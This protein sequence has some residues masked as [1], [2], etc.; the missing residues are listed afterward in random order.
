MRWNSCA[1]FCGILLLHQF[2]ALPSWPWLL[3][4]LAAGIILGKY[5]HRTALWFALGC[6]W[7][8]HDGAGYLARL[9]PQALEREELL[10][11]GRVASL[12]SGDAAVTRFLLDVDR[13]SRPGDGPLEFGGLVKLNWRGPLQ[14]PRGG[15]RW[16]LRVRLRQPRGFRNPGGFDYER[17]LFQEDIVATGYVRDAPHNRR[18]AAAGWSPLALRQWLRERIASGAAASPARGVLNALLI[19]DRGGLGESEWQLFRATGTSH[20]VA[21][22]GLHIGLVA[23]LAWMLFSSLWR[24]AGRLPLRLPAP[25]AGAWGALLAAAGYA[26]LAGFSVPTQRALVMTAVLCL[27]VILRRN[28]RPLDGV[29]LALLLV[30]LIDP[31]APL[32]AGFWLSFTAVGVILLLLERYPQRRG[33]RLWIAI[34]L[35][36]FVALLPLLALWGLPAAA[37]APLVNLLAVPWF[38]FVI[39]PGVLLTALLLALA[40]PGAAALLQL[41]L[42]GIELTL[43]ALQAV[44]AQG[45][46]LDLA[47][48]PW[49]QALPAAAGALLL[50]LARGWRW[51]AAGVPLLSLLAWPPGAAVEHLAV[52]VLDVGQ[53]ESLVVET[54]GHTLV[55]DLGPQFPG[56]FNSAAAVVLPWLRSRGRQRVDMLVLSHD[57][58]DHTGGAAQFAEQV[59]A[60]AI[61]TGQEMPQFGFSSSRCH[62]AAPWRWDGVSFRFLSTTLEPRNDNEASCVLL[63]EHAGGRV[64]I[65]GD[66]TARVETALLGAYSELLRADLATMPHHGS[67]T[68]SSPAFVRRVKARQVV[69]S[70]GWKSRY[71]H[72]RE[73]ILQRWRASGAAIDT[74]AESGAIRIAWDGD[75]RRTLSRYRQRARRFWHR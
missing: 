64:L 74:T 65:S 5:L 22:S 7:A 21:I 54:R 37:L 47:P 29:A 56:G 8:A 3:L 20:L 36:L 45:G 23:L 39:V 27:A 32:A 41:L 4:A 67:R 53:G 13:A 25:V 73:E 46:L 61:L 57:D 52:S 30:L 11:E 17:W 12:P 49:W 14:L 60:G 33:W 2:S 68:S 44:A 15:E 38:S 58:N 28:S 10:V 63:L 35:G 69:V 70:A 42:Q 34:Q 75:G 62:D 6:C 18:L 66:I 19:G 9:L 26:M 50:L 51:R 55:Y 16:R 31:R 71:G 40:A 43:G 72:P 48:L 59:Q 24:R 1:F